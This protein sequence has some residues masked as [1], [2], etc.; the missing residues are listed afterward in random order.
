MSL[1][2]QYKPC[3]K[4]GDSLKEDVYKKYAKKMRKAQKRKPFSRLNVFL[5]GISIGIAIGERVLKKI[6]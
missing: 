6:E 5:A 3:G 2:S 1:H 4:G